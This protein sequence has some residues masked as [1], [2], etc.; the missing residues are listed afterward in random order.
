MTRAKQPRAMSPIGVA[1]LL[2]ERARLQRR[3]EQQV[4]E[5]FGRQGYEEVI[6]PLVEYLDVMGPAL[7]GGLADRAYTFADRSTGRLMMLRPDV[8]PQIARMVAQLLADQPGPFRFCYRATV[9]RHEEAHAGRDREVVQI[10]A[11]LIGP[12]D[13]EADAEIITLALSALEKLG[14]T[15]CRAAIGHLGI[16]AGLLEGVQ[17]P[18]PAVRELRDALA[19]RDRAELLTLA[20]GLLPAKSLRRLE[21]LLDGIGQADILGRARERLHLDDGGLLA[22]AIQ[23]LSAVY[24]RVE[25][26]GFGASLLIDLGEVRGFDYYTG[27]VFDLF[28]DGVGY[29]IGGGGRYDRLIG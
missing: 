11:E 28:V 2:P 6:P 26:A 14:V 18:E 9:F 21:V 24:K 19:R 20:K 15:G 16:F 3:L 23:R 22:D 13:A 29:E 27:I 25:A 4:L 10:G 1:S 12:N 5:H 8:T 7:G 17:A